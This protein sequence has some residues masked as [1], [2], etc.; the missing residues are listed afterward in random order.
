VTS[1]GLPLWTITLVGLSMVFLDQRLATSLFAWLPD[2]I[3]T[4]GV[5]GWGG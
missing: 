4:M 2:A 1:A 3:G 5:G